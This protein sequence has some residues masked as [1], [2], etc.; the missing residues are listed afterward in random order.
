MGLRAQRAHIKLHEGFDPQQTAVKDMANDPGLQT[1]AR[2]H[3]F[4]QDS[5]DKQGTGQ[6]DLAGEYR[7]PTPARG[8]IVGVRHMNVPCQY[9]RAMITADSTIYH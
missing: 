6:L 7:I 1:Q 5:L 3:R 2:P 4:Q 9:G 8:F